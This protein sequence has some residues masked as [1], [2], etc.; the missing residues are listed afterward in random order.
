M[1]NFSQLVLRMLS[2]EF[3]KTSKGEDFD[4]ETYQRQFGAFQISRVLH[5]YDTYRALKDKFEQ[6]Y[7]IFSRDQIMKIQTYN[8]AYKHS[9]L[10]INCSFP[11]PHTRSAYGLQ[12][13][14]AQIHERTVRLNRWMG[15]LLKLFPRFPLAAQVS[16]TPPPPTHCVLPI[17]N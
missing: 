14:E 3:L 9:A 15:E 17:V 8:K 16:C 10:V 4:M 5:I 1:N 13:T 2:P 12:L 11:R 7:G 6:D